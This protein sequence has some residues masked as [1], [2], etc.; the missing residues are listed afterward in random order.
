M[1]ETR[2]PHTH[3]QLTH[4][5]Y[6]SGRKSCPRCRH[7]I[8]TCK[9]AERQSLPEH[10]P[11]ASL[12]S[13]QAYI[14]SRKSCPRC[15]HVSCTCRTKGDPIAAILP[16]APPGAFAAASKV[17]A[18]D[19]SARTRTTPQAQAAPPSSNEQAHEA[20]G[21]PRTESP[22]ISRDVKTPVGAHSCSPPPRTPPP[23]AR[24]DSTAPSGGEAEGLLLSAGG[25]KRKSCPRCKHVTCTCR[26][27]L[28][29]SHTAHPAAE[30]A[31]TNLQPLA[32]APLRER[33][34]PIVWDH[35]ASDAYMQDLVRARKMWKQPSVVL[36][37]K[38]GGGSERSGG[39][40][41]GDSQGGGSPSNLQGGGVPGDAKHN[42]VVDDRAKRF[43]NSSSPCVSQQQQLQSVS[44]GGASVGSLGGASS[45]LAVA[46]GTEAS[47]SGF[48]VG[49]KVIYRD[50]LVRASLSA[51][52]LQR[53]L[54]GA[55]LWL[56][57]ST[58][59][60]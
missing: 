57:F 39:S 44:Q 19:A 6:R 24:E 53:F 37:R 46:K 11:L 50:D 58:A 28:S 20:A 40:F 16:E 7:V 35:K 8:C 26:G 31:S 12:A 51:S 14:S 47:E 2:N 22:S 18:S 5:N 33:S 55:R 1:C 42:V 9:G 43:R 15:R 36:P 60:V 21:Q 49:M 3:P 23:I 13:Y 52:I 59:L 41:Q 34:A 25:G 4:E 38:R 32:E 48:R 10:S 29:D 17:K 27:A 56:C 54:R 45:V 30:I